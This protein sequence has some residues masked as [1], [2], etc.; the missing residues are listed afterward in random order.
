MIGTGPEDNFL[1]VCDSY[2]NRGRKTVE[3]ADLPAGAN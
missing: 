1:R 2:Q 3:N